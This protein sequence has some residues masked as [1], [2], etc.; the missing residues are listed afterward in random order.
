METLENVNSQFAK[1][2]LVKEKIKNTEERVAKLKLLT[3]NLNVLKNNQLEL[4]AHAIRDH[5]LTLHIGDAK[6]WLSDLY[7]A[8]N[9]FS[10][11]INKAYTISIGGKFSPDKKEFKF[12]CHQ[13]KQNIPIICG[14]W[15]E[16][17]RYETLFRNQKSSKC[18]F[19]E[20]KNQERKKNDEIKL[21]F[22]FKG[23][24]D[25]LD[26]I[27]IL[28]E[29]QEVQ[30]LR[31]MAYSDYLLTEHWQEIRQRAL[32]NASYRCQLCNDD[33]QLDVHHRTYERRGCERLEDLTVL[34]RNCHG[35]HHDK[36]P[37]EFKNIHEEYEA[38]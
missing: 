7:W 2:E 8:N 26:P 13:C 33:G 18:K 29:V 35:K 23:V 27:P 1:L 17:S 38:R 28:K 9:M 5:I 3:D 30:R 37:R 4:I 14:S 24:N 20:E 36:I 16:Y 32:K 12:I 31:K 10:S 15:T 22:I 21:P 34:C 11:T 6:K 25:S 19:C